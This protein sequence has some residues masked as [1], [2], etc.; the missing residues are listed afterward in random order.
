MPLSLEARGV[1]RALVQYIRNVRELQV[2]VGGRIRS[3][4]PGENLHS[5]VAVADGVAR[6]CATEWVF[7][8]GEVFSYTVLW[9]LS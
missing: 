8:F 2:E 6:P 4:R 9:S 1:L 5:P 3:A 7:G